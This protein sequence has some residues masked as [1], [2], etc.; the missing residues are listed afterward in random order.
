MRT[1]VVVNQAHTNPNAED[2]P[3]IN[4]EQLDTHT[5]RTAV[6]V[7]QAHV[8][9]RKSKLWQKSRAPGSPWN[10]R[11]KHYCQVGGEDLSNKD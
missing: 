3:A 6:V 11:A 8:R 5:M 4:R 9:R 7:N 1:A 2:K 10:A